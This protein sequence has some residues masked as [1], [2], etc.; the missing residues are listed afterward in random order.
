MRWLLSEAHYPL[1]Q[2]LSLDSV[3]E[4]LSLDSV[5][6]ANCSCYSYNFND[7]KYSNLCP[8]PILR[9]FGFPYGNNGLGVRVS[10]GCLSINNR[11]CYNKKKYSK[12]G[13]HMHCKLGTLL[14]INGQLIHEILLT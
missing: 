8:F 1:T 3:L 13:K 6:E 2:S 10:I 5:V 12:E 11:V 14:S 9:L 7:D 4:A